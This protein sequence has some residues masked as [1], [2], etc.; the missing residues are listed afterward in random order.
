MSLGS[1]VFVGQNGHV[2]PAVVVADNGASVDVVVFDYA[3]NAT[4]ILRS[5]AV[6]DNAPDPHPVDDS[7]YAFSKLTVS[8]VVTT[9]DVTVTDSNTST[10]IAS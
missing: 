4:T 3:G 10:D 2:K 1:S 9:A 6:T 7:F 8:P 5:V